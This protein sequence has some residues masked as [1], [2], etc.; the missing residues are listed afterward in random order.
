MPASQARASTSQ[1]HLRHE[2]HDHNRKDHP[3]G[4]SNL[5]GAECLAPWGPTGVHKWDAV[6][7][8]DEACGRSAVQ[9]KRCIES[10][11]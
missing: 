10:P 8:G 3:T 11:D 2:V 5:K 1:H 9:V 4:K 7:V 6:I